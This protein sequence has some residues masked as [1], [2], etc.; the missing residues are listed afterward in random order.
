MI[1]V[2]PTSEGKAVGSDVII[3]YQHKKKVDQ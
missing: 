2:G 1:H 3:W